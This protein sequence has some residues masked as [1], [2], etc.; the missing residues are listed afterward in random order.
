MKVHVIGVGKMG[1]PMARHLLA[2][3]HSVS[4][5]DPSA[6]RLALAREAG[7]GVADGLAVAEVVVSSL[8]HDGALLAV[9]ERVAA[10]AGKEGRGV[11]WVDTSTVSPEAS[12]RAAEACARAGL[13][14]LRCTVS[15][16]N[17]M[18]EAAQL[19]VM[20][21]GPKALHERLLPLLRC[22]GPTQFWLGEAEEARLMKLVVNLMI[23]QTSAML[24]EALSLGQKGGLA[25]ADMWNVIGASA[26]AS[27]IVKAKSVQLSQRDY[28]PTFT[29]GQMNKDIDLILGEGARLRVPLTQTAA[30]RQL[31]SAAQAQGDEALDYAAIIRVMQRA[32]GLPAD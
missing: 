1:L 22:W 17:H 20:A 19:T 27:P 7:L 14:S 26:V 28:T 31:M 8:P 24:A 10:H 12:A 16:N 15:G 13:Q 9:S 5:E 11:A 3:G 18:A 30:T 29:V 2:A 32:A 23:A 4:V 21:S 25:W 6:E